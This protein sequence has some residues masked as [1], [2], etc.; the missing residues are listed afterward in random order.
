M[1]VKTVYLYDAA[2]GEYAG[3]YDAQESPLEP[4]VFVR[5]EKSLDDAPPPLAANQTAVAVNGVWVV[6]PDFRKTPLY[7]TV[8]GSP[9]EITGIGPM[10]A[11]ATET[12]RPPGTKWDNG[13]WVEDFAAMAAT[14]LAKFR[15][16][17]KEMFA[18][19]AGMGWAASATN[20]TATETK[21]L[22]FR[23]GLKDLPEWPAVV[24][25]TTHAGLK[26]AMVARY[27]T[28][29]GALPVA[30]RDDFKKLMP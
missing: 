30:V 7:S 22:A 20:D 4:G 8:D 5:P 28:L 12:P 25:A 29:T 26:A 23:E 21:L 16:D 19:I 2:T 1:T 24:A 10:P 11:N 17:R 18:V 6:S 13:A 14:E 27:K 3:T 15:N 9:L